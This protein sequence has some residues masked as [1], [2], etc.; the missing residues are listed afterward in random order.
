MLEE[1]LP[2]S[3]EDGAGELSV[4]SLKLNGGELILE[5]KLPESVENVGSFKLNNG[6]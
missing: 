6:E 3:I 2:E 1:R 4:G 5:A